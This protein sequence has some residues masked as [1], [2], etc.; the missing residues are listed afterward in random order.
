MEQKLK[1]TSLTVDRTSCTACG[2]CIDACPM[3][4]LELVDDYCVLIDPVRCLECETCVRGC[5]EKAI[6]I[7]FRDAVEAPRTKPVSITPGKGKDAIPPSPP[8]Y[9]PVLAT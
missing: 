7:Q 4:I 6:T 5:P 1:E 8:G 3:M 2:T 9:T